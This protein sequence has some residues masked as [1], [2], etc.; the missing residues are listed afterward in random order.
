MTPHAVHRCS[1]MRGFWHTISI[2]LPRTLHM[3]T[4]RA[5]VEHMQH[6]CALAWEGLL[7]VCASVGVCLRIDYQIQP[8]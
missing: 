2:R 7:T 5:S 1:G 8:M 4:V 6:T 3:Y